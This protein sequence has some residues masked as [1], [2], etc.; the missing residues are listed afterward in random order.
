MDFDVKITGNSDE[1]SSEGDSISDDLQGI[2]GNEV[3]NEFGG[4]TIPISR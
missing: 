4:Q 1:E 2:N 3:F